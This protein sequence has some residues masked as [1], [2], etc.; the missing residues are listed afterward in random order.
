[1]SSESVL[2][3]LSDNCA[4]T[5]TINKFISCS[6]AEFFTQRV[7]GNL[8]LEGHSRQ[9]GTRA[10]ETLTWAPKALCL[11][12]SEILQDIMTTKYNDTSYDCA[13]PMTKSYHS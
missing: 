3:T 9:L 5:K 11:A 13:H 8:A 7:K 1:M 4:Q 6:V 2:P 10:L 12:D